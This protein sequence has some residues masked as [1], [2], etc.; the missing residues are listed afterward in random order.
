MARVQGSTQPETLS[1][2][3]PATSIEVAG[4]SF[5]KVLNNFTYRGAVYA[6]GDEVPIKEVIGW[7]EDFLKDRVLYED[8]ELL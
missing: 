1:K 7:S 2:I 6:A 4:P 8:A 5:L 3:E